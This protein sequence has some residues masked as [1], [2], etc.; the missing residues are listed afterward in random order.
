MSGVSE[1]LM[2]IDD[3]VLQLLRVCV[4]IC[5]VCVHV[6]VYTVRV[7][8]EMDATLTNYIKNTK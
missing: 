7:W 4:R 5:R 8:R 2:F 1:Q 6:F 3:Y